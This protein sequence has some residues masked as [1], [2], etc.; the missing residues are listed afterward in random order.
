MK[1]LY[2]RTSARPTGADE[3]TFLI[4]LYRQNRIHHQ[5]AEAQDELSPTAVSRS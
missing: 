4:E 2:R 1:S 3:E 5:F